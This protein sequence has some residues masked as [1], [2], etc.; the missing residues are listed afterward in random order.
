MGIRSFIK[1]KVNQQL[2]SSDVE[3]TQRST[4]ADTRSL[5]KAKD[6]EGFS[7]VLRVDDLLDGQGR[8]VAVDAIGIAVFRNG[9]HFFAIDD[10]CTHEDAPLGE[11]TVHG[12]TVACPYHDWVF[13][14]R[15]GRCIS[16][17]D[18]QV[19]CFATKIHDGFVWIGPR[20]S[21]GSTERGGDHA[22]GLKT[23]EHAS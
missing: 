11:G 16:Y 12:T 8:T 18:R 9:E 10:A 21:D 15:D 13:D 4:N 7:A 3:P 17:P 2:G 5:P 23:S 6:A 19:G 22:D 20:T 14:F 1:R